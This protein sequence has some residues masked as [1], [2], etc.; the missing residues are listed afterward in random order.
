MNIK[1]LIIIIIVLVLAVNSFAQNENMRFNHID[2]KTGLSQNLINCITQDSVGFLWFGTKD[3]LNRYDGYNFKVF[4]NEFGNKNSISDNF[5]TELYVDSNSNLWVGTRNGLNLYNEQY[6]NFIQIEPDTL[7]LLNDKKNYITKIIEDKNGVIWSSFGDSRLLRIEK[8]SNS[9]IISFQTKIFDL[10]KFNPQFSELNDIEIDKYGNLWGASGNGLFKINFSDENEFIITKVHDIIARTFF[11]NNNHLY[12][13]SFGLFYRI[14]I[15]EPEN[16]LKEFIIFE[17]EKK[18][19]AWNYAVNQIIKNDENTLLFATA[20]GLLNYNINSNSV[21]YIHSRENDSQSLISDNLISI[22]KDHSENLWI[23]TAG[24]GINK[25][26]INNSKFEYYP[27]SYFARPSM[28]ILN[29]REDPNGTIW[30]SNMGSLIFKLNKQS[31]EAESVDFSSKSQILYYDFLIMPDNTFWALKYAQ[32]EKLNQSK[33]IVEVHKS[34]IVDKNQIPFERIIGIENNIIWIAAR[35]GVVKFD[36]LKKEFNFFPYPSLKDVLILSVLKGNS[37]DLWIG[38]ESGLIRFMI[39]TKEW[40]LYQKGINKLSNERIKSI[41]YDPID[42]LNTLWIGT[43]GGGLNKLNLA[44]DEIKIFGS[45]EGLPNSVVYGILTDNNKNIWLSTNMGLSS[46]DVVK[47][48]FRNYNVFD[49]LQDNEFNSQAYYKGKDGKLYFGGINGLTVFDPDELSTNKFIPRIFFTSFKINNELIEPNT[50]DSPLEKV[51]GFTDSIELPYKKNNLSF[52]FTSLDFT[53]SQN[54]KYKYMLEGFDDEFQYNGKNREA[55]YT[56]LAPGNYI[57]RVIGSNNDE[58]W[59]ETGASVNIIINEP[60]WLTWWA[61]L[62]YGSIFMITVALIIKYQKNKVILAK[63]YEISELEKQKFIEINQLKSRFLTNIT[64]EFR[65]PLTLVIG[66]VEELILRL[67][68]KNAV[69]SLELV[70]YNA[71]HLL[72]LVNQLLELSRL[73]KE[74]LPVNISQNEL[75]QFIS[76]NILLLYSL[77]K[78][79]GININFKTSQKYINANFDSEILQKILSN[80]ISNSIKYT[81]N[82]G[83]ILISLRLLDLKTGVVEIIIEDNG[84]GIPAEEL[85]NIF[86]PFFRSSS[87][88]VFNTDGFG[89]GLSLTKEL[90]DILGGSIKAESEKNTKTIF[91]VRIPMKIDSH[92]DEESQFNFDDY[93]TIDEF[94]QDLK[95]N[96]Q[97]FSIDDKI[98]LVVD[99][100]KEMR[101][102]ISGIIEEDFKVITA[103]DGLEGFNKAIKAI[104]DIIISDVMMPNESGFGLLNKLKNEEITSHIPVILL[105][106]MADEKSKL[107]G[108]EIGADDYIVK[109]F[110]ANELKI[111][112]KNLINSREK[113][114]S[115][116]SNA[117]KEETVIKN[118]SKDEIFMEKVYSFIYSNLEKEN[119]SVEELAD[120]IGLSYSQVYRK[121]KSLTNQTTIQLIQSCRVKKAAELLKDKTGNISEIAY[122]VGFNNPSYFAQ[123]F[124]KEYNCT[125]Q[126][127]TEKFK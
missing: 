13:G 78:Q 117:A 26:N 51:I 73:D 76:D 92:F 24:Y 29:I 121:V 59:N 3:G 84:V 88:K 12:I 106:A 7:Q 91:K 68:D 80:L 9:N 42:S 81:P 52:K 99:D 61:Y 93:E 47:E 107:D 72:K 50:A 48:T 124:K 34:P 28:S 118:K 25:A 33:E 4:R 6:E 30:L 120:E 103:N 66:P 77:A 75:V 100:I 17:Q 110:N 87:S 109:P 104:P 36:I 123:C 116:Y 101:H 62:I 18:L 46:F 105:T 114:K 112:I 94:D 32:L 70:K 14:N 65:T 89:I 108:L 127:Y 53:A 90:V 67:K 115:K 111:R 49:G 96:N 119:L 113:L 63:Q 8:S 5:V 55:V 60:F 122:T 43:D 41:C 98:V 56:N 54:N 38:S 74:K 20:K 69:K 86:N 22:F 2:V 11:Y 85:R 45:K 15:D 37:N 44:T 1:K 19:E 21:T 31:G 58:V 39:H 83:D 97:E 10:R 16:S 35:N 57:F 79:K 64:H 126:E 23:G 71:K 82:S 95:F 125:P 40:K 27:A 102:Y